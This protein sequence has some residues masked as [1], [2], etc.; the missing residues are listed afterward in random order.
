MIAIDITAMCTTTTWSVFSINEIVIHLF[1]CYLRIKERVALLRYPD[2]PMH[3]KNRYYEIRYCDV[4]CFRKL[5][6]QKKK[7]ITYLID[8]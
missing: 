3:R 4:T 5:K 1:L 6:I 8:T 7:T 2:F